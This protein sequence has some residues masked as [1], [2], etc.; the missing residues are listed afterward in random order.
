MGL[1]AILVLFINC[2]NEEAPFGIR[3]G[4]DALKEISTESTSTLY[5][6][7]NFLLSIY[8]LIETTTAF[9]IHLL[10]YTTSSIT[11]LSSG[12]SLRRKWTR[13]L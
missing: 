6:L 13:H 11:I 4:D 2:R 12:S 10:V 7:F 1:A 9:Y 5:K 8:Q 3:S